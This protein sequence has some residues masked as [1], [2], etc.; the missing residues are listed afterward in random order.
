MA[1]YLLKCSGEQL[2]RYRGAAA[3]A[4]YSLAEFLRAAADSAADVVEGKVTVGA[5]EDRFH[6]SAVPVT[7]KVT[8][9]T[10]SVRRKNKRTVACEH[11]VPADAF[12]KRC[13]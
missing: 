9:R 12:C 6:P 13:D 7:R 1:Q 4:G 2:A 11:R 10:E 3:L 5:A 8:G